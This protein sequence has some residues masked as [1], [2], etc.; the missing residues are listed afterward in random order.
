MEKKTH[1]PCNTFTLA[2]TAIPAT[3]AAATTTK[4][5]TKSDHFNFRMEVP[6]RNQATGKYRMPLAS[7]RTDQRN[8]AQNHTV[9]G[10][11]AS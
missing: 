10:V 3:V 5:A 1:F 4:Q 2:T 7:V 9:Q 8:E 6:Y 11:I